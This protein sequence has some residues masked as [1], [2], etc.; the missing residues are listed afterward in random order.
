MTRRLATEP[1]WLS[2]TTV[3]AV[4]AQ[5]VERYGGQHGVRDEGLLYTL[6]AKPR[7]R[8]NYDENADLAFLASTYLTGLSRAHAFEAAN[9]RTALACTLLFLQLNN[10]HLN[11][12]PSDLL[13]LVLHSSTHHSYD[14]AAATTLR[15]HIARHPYSP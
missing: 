4:H 13:R 11:T 1:R 14:Q 10:S 3:L 15:P 5:L 6:L 2:E 7:Q 8:W 12:P 9:K